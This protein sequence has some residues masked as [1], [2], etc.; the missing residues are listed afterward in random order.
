M[1][2]EGVGETQSADK[3]HFFTHF[4][5]FFPHRTLLALGCRVVQVNP[6][7]ESSLKKIKLP[8]K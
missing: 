1:N 4:M 6:N 5:L 2:G 3:P 8:K 7:A